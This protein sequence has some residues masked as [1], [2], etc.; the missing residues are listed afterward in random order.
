MYVL[1]SLAEVKSIVLLT[2]VNGADELMVELFSTFF[3][4][5]SGTSKSSTGEQLSK[6]AEYNM[7]QILVTLVDE[8]ASLPSGVVD[9]VVAQFLRATS[10]PT[11]APKVGEKVDAKQSI[12][13][14]KELPP[15]YRMAEFLCNS[16][17][18]KMSRYISQYFND[19]IVEAST[20]GHI[21]NRRD[22]IAGE[23]D[24][25]DEHQGP[26]EAD[27]RELY[28]A[29]RLLRELWRASPNVLPNVIPQ[30][31]AELSAENVQLRMLATET[32]GDIISGIGAA[33]PPP[34]PVMDPAA[35]PPLKLDDY[36][37]AATPANILTTPMSPQSF[38]QGYGAVYNSFLSRRNDK[39]PIIRSSWTTAIGRIIVTS[40]GGIGLSREDE[41]SLIN[42]LAD[43][44]SDPD[45]RVR[46]AAVRAVGT[47]SLKD[48]VAKLGNNGGVNRRGSVL[49]NL[50]ERV[51][52]RRHNVRIEGMT[53]IARI[54]GVAAGEIAAG[55]ESV[56]ALLDGIPSKILDA[57][58]TNDKDI[59][60]LLDHV[61]FEQLFPLA[62]PPSKAKAKKAKSD[63]SNG[64]SQSQANADSQEQI[65]VDES[66]FD[67]N[68]IRTERLLLLVRSLDSKAKKVFFAMQASQPTMLKVIT[69]FLTEC[70]AYNGGV[71]D[72]G[73]DKDVKKRMTATINWLSQNLPDPPR[74]SADLWKYA[75]LHIRRTYALW[76]Y[77]MDSKSEFKTV[78]NAVKEFSK[79]MDSAPGG[80]GGLL[81]T[82][83]PLLYR[84][85]SI[86]YNQSHLPSILDYSRNDEKGLGATAHEL[87][88]EISEKNPDIFRAQV[89]D[90]CKLLVEEAPSKM[91]P[92]EPGSFKTLKACAGYARK[93]PQE[94]PKD[95]AL[96]IALVNFGKYG[97]P[98][99]A[100]KYAVTIIMSSVE[101][102]EML[103]EDLLKYAVTDWKF[104]EKHSITKLALISQICLLSKETAEPY[105]DE[106]LAIATTETLLKARTPVS[107]EDRSWVDDA[108][109]DDEILAKSWALRILVNNLLVISDP[110][111]ARQVAE[112]VYKTLNAL[113]KN[114]GELLRP[115]LQTPK[116]HRSRLT[117]L[118]AQLL[119]K[120]CRVKMFEDFL[121]FPAFVRLGTV[122]QASNFNVRRG[123][124]ERVQRYL[125]SGRLASRWYAVPFLVAFEPELSFKTSVETW[126]RS[127]AKWYAENESGK[128]V[129]E[130]LLP[131]LM[132]LLAHHP[133]FSADPADLL[134]TAQYLILFVSI[135]ATES[136]IGILFKYAQRVKQARDAI[137]PEASESLY[138]LSDLAQV[139]IR[140]WEAKKGWTMQAYAGKVG[141]TKDLFAAMPDHRTAQETADKVFVPEEMEDAVEGAVK[142]F[143]RKRQGSKRKLEDDG[144]EKPAAAKKA[145]S[146]FSRPSKP[147]AK[148][149]GG[150]QTRLKPRAAP[151]P[152]TPARPARRRKSGSDDDASDAETPSAAAAA[153]AESARRRSVRS[154]NRRK[155]YV[156]RE[157][158]LD[159]EEML[160]GVAE[161]EYEDGHLERG[162]VR[163]DDDGDVEMTE[164]SPSKPKAKGRPAPK[165]SSPPLT[166]AED[167]P[168][169]DEE[170]AEAD[171]A[172][173][174]SEAVAEAESEAEEPEDQPSPPPRTNGRAARGRAAPKAKAV[175]AKEASPSPAPSPAKKGRA[176]PA[177]KAKKVLPTR[178]SG[179]GKK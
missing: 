176:R 43:M 149:S 172:A 86:V 154:S 115:P 163:S 152:K 6:N 100:A 49:A 120:L 13:Q 20:L 167:E 123:F 145:R 144:D 161:W 148:P 78:H 168:E 105:T 36:D 10:P 108:S 146:S 89:K 2:D 25:E 88:K 54:W 68:K 119:L 177:L 65:E 58:Y 151:K 169:A 44:L 33:G 61:M 97:E 30:L 133:D 57:F 67:P 34:P 131:R 1:T 72:S 141:L 101:R 85:G 80:Q 124:V 21:K 82:L 102:K 93:F 118:A 171:S 126:L 91:K 135:V 22:S 132:S 99:K 134:D 64:A 16:C 142:A 53:T 103:L 107:A 121:T 31:E 109:L 90:L 153:A 178:S 139:V 47:F 48:V 76:R 18:E 128:H 74:A 69:K 138:V 94:I 39:S 14:I 79:M 174:G 116:H 38:A 24:E 159:E 29:H 166:E 50:A 111:T 164:S 52:D 112:P 40:A 9:I 37:Q 8:A 32:L 127:R 59:N 114:E 165:S 104:G 92:N 175:A 106:I 150:T 77:A 4:M 71:M 179:R 42:S 98:A 140:K 155:S 129:F 26:T 56:I 66:N 157:E 158:S 143:E 173:E 3:D 137:T 110:E 60:V 160:E 95:R 113:I 51:R 41:A 81:D 147:A 87:L 84:S 73:D 170:A 83:I 12:L 122:A 28:K 46:L 11:K 27:L 70:E 45:E 15:A 117:L 136:N 35:Y 125:V 62:Y 130:A 5:V 63:K 23:S 96:V 162:S 19:V 7:N 55:N 17:P 156:E 75:K